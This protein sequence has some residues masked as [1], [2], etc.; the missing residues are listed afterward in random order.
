MNK[1]PL[2]KKFSLTK[3]V[4]AVFSVI[5]VTACAEPK[6]VELEE[7]VQQT[8]NLKDYDSDGVVK[9]RDKCDFS[10][11]NALVNNDG[12]GSQ[13]AKIDPFK[14]NINF[15]NNS[16]EIPSKD[17]AEIKKLADFLETHPELKVMIEGHTSNVGGEELNQ[18]LSANRAEAVVFVLVNDFNIDEKRVSSIGYGFSRLK[19]EGDTEK[20]HAAN[21]R[22][23]GQL[24]HIEHIDELKWTIYSVDKAN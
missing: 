13:T 23:M 11:E 14:I 4:L 21:R 10:T 20:A 19:E 16:A 12:C 8:N 17:Y 6:I 15:D 24:S 7:S 3:C 5:L 1:S 22:I 2:E 9:A 18:A